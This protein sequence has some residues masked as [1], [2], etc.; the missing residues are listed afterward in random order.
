MSKK[1]EPDLL[2][3]WAS[4]PKFAGKYRVKPGVSN[5][6]KP[7]KSQEIQRR[8][9]RFVKDE[10]TAKDKKQYTG[11]KMIGVTVLHKSCLQPVFNQDA[12]IDAARM[13]R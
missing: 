7:V 2:A 3:K 6:P 13:R 8:A 11:G 12:A 9:A 10:G 4:V 5:A 1:Q